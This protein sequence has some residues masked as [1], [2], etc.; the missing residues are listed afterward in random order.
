MMDLEIKYRNGSMVIHL[1]AF[2]DCRSITKVR[3]LVKV[4]QGSYTTDALDKMKEFVE[5]QLEQFEPRMKEDA[6]YIVG[7]KPKLKFSQEQLNKSVSIRSRFK[8]NSEGWKQYNEQV[9]QQREEVRT[10]KAQI[11]SRDSDFNSCIRNK[12]FYEKVL[13]TIS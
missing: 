4:I 12:A 6:R 13:E 3:K 8:R 10:L 2:L 9:K 1:E 7:Y 5:R 11:R